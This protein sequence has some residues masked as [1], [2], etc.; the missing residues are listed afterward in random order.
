MRIGR[1]GTE[2]AA[3]RHLRVD[4]EDELEIEFGNLRDSVDV[5]NEAAGDQ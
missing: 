5:E 2:A 3:Y 4:E 1:R